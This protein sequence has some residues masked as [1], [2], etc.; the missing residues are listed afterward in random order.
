VGFA[1]GAYD[2]NLPLIIDPVVLAY[3]TFLGGAGFD[4]G[5]AIAVDPYTRQA[6][7]TGQTTNADTDFPTTPGAFDQTQNDEA[8]NGFADAFVTKLAPSGAALG[9]STFLGGSGLDN[10]AGIAVD[11]AGAA[12]VTGLSNS[13]DFPTTAWLSTSP[14]TG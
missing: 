14:T 6:Y 3:S 2:P 8:H 11:G 13:A 4:A 9:Y 10:G 1:L 7:V 12:Y 5:S